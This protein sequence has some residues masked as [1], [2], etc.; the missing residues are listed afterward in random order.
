MKK[1]DSRGFAHHILLVAVVVLGVAGIGY[2]V[3]QKS[4]ADSFVPPA[5]VSLEFGSSDWQTTGNSKIVTDP[6]QGQV[7]EITKAG[8]AD[9]NVTLASL[10]AAGTAKLA[11]LNTF[12]YNLFHA[13]QS[14]YYVRTC[15]T[16]KTVLTN[17]DVNNFPY[18][19]TFQIRSSTTPD[20]SFLTDV[21]ANGWTTNKCSVARPSVQI[22]ASGFFSSNKLSAF[23]KYSSGTSLTGRTY[24]SD[25]GNL[26]PPAAGKAY[27]GKVTV[28]ASSTQLK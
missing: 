10:N 19:S 5:P 16:Y 18:V 15:V 14:S 1:L 12:E 4:S 25:R 13:R 6:E 9:D 28:T 27:I 26:N 22:K 23:T 2:Y 11:Q 24:L 3:Y 17:Q 8:Q 21:Y 20:I 7:L